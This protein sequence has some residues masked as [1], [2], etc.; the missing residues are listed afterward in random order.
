M[1][2]I[3]EEPPDSRAP[4]RDPGPDLLRRNL[5]AVRERIARAARRAG[6]DPQDATLV[7]VTKSVETDI[8]EHL[9]SLGAIDLGENRIQVAAPKIE[10]LQS[11]PTW[12]LIGHLQTNKARRAVALF[13]WIHAVD[14]VSLFDRLERAADDLELRPRVLFQVNVSG[15]ESKFGVS[16]EELPALLE[17]AAGAKRLQPVGLMTMAPMCDDPEA[18]R[19][20]FRMLREL[21]LEAR[22][23]LSPEFRHLSMGMTN[24]FEVAV[25]E[26][27]TLVRVG[28]ALFQ[29]QRQSGDSP[30]AARRQPGGD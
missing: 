7:A 10:R 17:R 13:S 4:A 5:Q 22:N 25:E 21:L 2:P 19:P 27:A 30:E 20:H 26:G 23:R 8:I 12:H 29:V 18:A 1:A 28:S 9:V 14:S 16:V 6:R 11:G 3:R 24:D 15:E